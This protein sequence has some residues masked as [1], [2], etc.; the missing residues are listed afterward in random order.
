MVFTVLLFE[1]A[2][3]IGVR[4]DW[5]ADVALTAEMRADKNG[6]EPE[7]LTRQGRL[8]QPLV[9]GI[10]TIP[11]GNAVFMDDFGMYYVES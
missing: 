8:A 10:Q 9:L 7:R 5:Q 4:V 3:E 11:A 6:P 2:E 1:E